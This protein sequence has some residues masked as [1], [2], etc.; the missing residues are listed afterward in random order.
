MKIFV[1]LFTKAYTCLSKLGDLTQ[2]FLLLFFRIN[3]GFLFFI[4]GKGK[5]INH[6][7]VVSF[8]S[9]LNLPA[10]DLTAWF[11][12]IVECLGGL[13]LLFGLATRPVG[14][15]LSI[16]MLVAYLSVEEDRNKLFN[17]FGNQDAF[18][19]SDPFFFLLAA[20]MAF[21]FGG[22]PFSL[23]TLLKRIIEKRFQ[24]GKSP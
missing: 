23:D 4:T 16:N 7:Q 14:L 15:I 1:S 20:L 10:P 22:G 8:F 9:S 17:F 24:I 18:F 3:W 5:L 6:A 11:V 13:L 12:A 19:Q 2:L 21:A